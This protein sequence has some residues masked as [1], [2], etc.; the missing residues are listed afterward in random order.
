MIRCVFA[1]FA[2]AAAAQAPKYDGPVPSKPD[3]PYLKHV[4]NLVETEPEQI[5]EEKQADDTVYI[6]AGEN[7]SAKTP[8]PLPVFLLKTD[9]LDPL[10]LE[11]YRLTTGDGRRQITAAGKKT[12]DRIHVSVTRLAPALFR[13]EVTDALDDGEYMLN[14]NGTDEAFCFAVH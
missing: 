3:L 7:S 14:V 2:L 4:G 13:L 1:L 9:K 8:L 6:I 12:A 5:R 10:K 11:L